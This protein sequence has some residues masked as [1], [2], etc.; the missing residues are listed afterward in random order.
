MKWIAK[1]AVVLVCY[2]LCGA[3]ALFV[4]SSPQ[5]KLPEPQRTNAIPVKNHE[6]VR[7]VWISV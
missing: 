1:V 2:A 4:A 6:L 3:A 7:R 5:E